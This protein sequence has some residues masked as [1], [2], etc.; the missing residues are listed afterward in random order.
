MTS[1]RIEQVKSFSGLPD[2]A[3]YL[4]I[5]QSSHER[6]QASQG[7]DQDDFESLRTASWW[8]DSPISTSLGKM[9]VVDETSSKP[10]PAYHY[11]VTPAAIN[12]YW[13]LLRLRPDSRT[14]TRCH[15]KQA[16]PSKMDDGAQSACMACCPIRNAIS[17]RP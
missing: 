3:I 10:A 5:C 4:E 7:G 6:V 11:C 13:T 17:T 9:D 14:C 15:D 8:L 1:R 2:D 16:N 12:L